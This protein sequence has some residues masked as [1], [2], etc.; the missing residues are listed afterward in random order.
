M[1]P[2]FYFH[3]MDYNFSYKMIVWETVHN[4]AANLIK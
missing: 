4:N 1:R 3:D 2:D